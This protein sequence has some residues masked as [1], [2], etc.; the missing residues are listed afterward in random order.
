M[1]KLMLIDGS[2]MLH[3]SFYG[4]LPRYKTEE[5][6]EKAFK[7]AMKTED[8][9]YTNGAFTMTDKILKLIKHQKPTHMVVCWDVNR[10]ILLR[11]K[12]YAGYKATREETRPELSQQFPVM[13]D[14]LA[15]MGI[16]QTRLEGHEADDI[17]GT[18]VERFEGKIPVIVITKDK[19][20]LQLV[21]EHTSVWMPTREAALKYK[22]RGIDPRDLEV[23]HN[24]FVYD[25]QTFEDEYGL[26][27]HQIIDLKAL[28]GDSSDN[29]PGVKGVGSVKA[30]EL[31]REYGTIEKL[32]ESIQGKDQ[33]E[34]K[35]LKEQLAQKG[36]TRV[37]LGA[38]LKK[39]DEEYAGE[40]AALLSKE[41]A[42]IERNLEAYSTLPLERL[43]VR[44]NHDK[45]ERIFKKYGFYSILKI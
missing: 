44:I 33:K 30:T 4:S 27:P 41:L 29:I 32:Y 3:S 42:T 34:L 21:S 45:K 22:K 23:P 36:I 16:P 7:Q 28:E 9:V 26:E 24:M 43:K 11:R 13:Q 38:L 8:G 31:L 12:K 15:H 20:C 6:K 19:D 18:L 40:K 2:S 35:K 5:E 39:S 1:E 14:I 37:P 10:D 25:L 17:I